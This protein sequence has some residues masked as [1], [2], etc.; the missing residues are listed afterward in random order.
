MAGYDKVDKST[1]SEMLEAR[2]RGMNNHQISEH[3]GL[4]YKTVL[5]HIG[6]Q[7]IGVRA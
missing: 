6:R 7:P 1:V 4:C 5:N 2:E 3:F